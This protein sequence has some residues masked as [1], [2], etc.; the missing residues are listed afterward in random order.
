M[1]PYKLR[2][3]RWKDGEASSYFFTCARPGRTSK[4]ESKKAQ[5]QTL[6]FAVGWPVSLGRGR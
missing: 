3:W 1:K 6:L 5:V 2:C 4:E